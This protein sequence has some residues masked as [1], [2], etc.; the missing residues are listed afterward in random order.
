MKKTISCR[1]IEERTK[2]FKKNQSLIDFLIKS[3]SKEEKISLSD[4]AYFNALM[5][6]I[7]L[8]FDL[9]KLENF[10]VKISNLEKWFKDYVNGRF[11]CFIKN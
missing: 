11:S 6:D 10:L 5:D 8:N 4:R 3:S 2:F 9:E 1:S 7:E